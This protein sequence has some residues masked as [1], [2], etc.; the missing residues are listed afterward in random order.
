MVFC[1]CRVTK[2]KC[3][4]Q[5]SKEPQCW[6]RKYQ[7]VYQNQ[8]L[9]S[10]LQRD[11]SGFYCSIFP[12][13]FF[14]F[15]G[16]LPLCGGLLISFC[17][18]LK[19]DCRLTKEFSEQSQDC[20]KT[21]ENKKINKQNGHVDLQ[22]CRNISVMLRDFFFL[23]KCDSEILMIEIC[24]FQTHLPVSRFVIMNLEIIEL[25]CLWMYVIVLIIVFVLGI[26]SLFVTTLASLGI[27]GRFSELWIALRTVWMAL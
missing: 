22:T 9:S 12:L 17:N 2:R 11:S 13:L 10:D 26:H 14:F 1:S 7:R 19:I 23:W 20:K 25:Q 3:S 5:S 6:R 8:Q 18:V 27:Y 24:A 15:F 21:I 4:L 16:D